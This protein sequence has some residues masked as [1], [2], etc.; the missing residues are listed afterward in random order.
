M[1][2][3]T[4][5]SDKHVRCVIQQTQNYG[6]T[7]PVGYRARTPNDAEKRYDRAEWEYLAMVWSLRILRTYIEGALFTIQ[8]DQDSLKCILNLSDST[9][10]LA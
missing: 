6:T 3:D 4:D 7:T 5:E 10:R 9:G 2:L 8:S 1:T